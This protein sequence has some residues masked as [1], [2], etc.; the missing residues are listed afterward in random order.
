[1]RD[2]LIQNCISTVCDCMCGCIKSENMLLKTFVY[3]YIY[4]FLKVAATAPRLT[5]DN[6]YIDIPYVIHGCIRYD[7]CIY[8]PCMW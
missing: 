1:M 8:L 7:E 5:D 4:R 3:T 2:S 6:F